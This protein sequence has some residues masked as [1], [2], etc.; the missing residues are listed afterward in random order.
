MKY[1]V[2]EVF[3]LLGE[4]ALSITEL[5]L[6]RDRESIEVE[7]YKVYTKSLRYATFYQK[8]CKCCSCGKEGKYFQLDSGDSADRRHFNLYAADGTLMTK[9][10]ILPKRHGGQNTVDNL[11]T[12][13]VI[14]NRAKGCKLPSNATQ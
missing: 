8:G 3:N 5:G 7:G 9:D 11:Q 12:M 6:K 10:H 14:C 2:E 1:T 4:E 13:C